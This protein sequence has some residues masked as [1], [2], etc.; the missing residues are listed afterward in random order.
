MLGTSTKDYNK[1]LLS[2][3]GDPLVIV[4]KNEI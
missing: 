3:I 4:Q 2:G 1:T